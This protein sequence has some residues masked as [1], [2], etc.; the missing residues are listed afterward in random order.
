VVGVEK[1]K[2]K[3][4]E[5]IELRRLNNKQLNKK[6]AELR[7]HLCRLES[8]FRPSS[9]RVAYGDKRVPPIFSEIKKR[10]AFIKTILRE[11]ELENEKSKPY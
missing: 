11:R 9:T 3:K 4:S 10:I 8:S 5:K 7:N 1:R 2:M 6:L